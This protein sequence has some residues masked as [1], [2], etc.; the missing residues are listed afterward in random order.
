M[1]EREGETQRTE[2]RIVPLELEVVIIRCNS[3]LLLSCTLT[4]WIIRL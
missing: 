4:N 1:S 3:F 2:H